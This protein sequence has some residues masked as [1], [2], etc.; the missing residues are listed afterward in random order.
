VNFLSPIHLFALA[1]VA[2]P[3]LIH[4]FSRRRVPEIPFSTIRFLRRSDRRSMVRINVRRL[5]LL[6]LRILAV[7]CIAMAFARPVVRGALASL[8]PAGGSRAACILLDRSYSMGIEGDEGAA[9]DRGLARLASILDNLERGDA[10]AIVLFDTATD[11]LYDGELEKAAALGALKG[12]RPSWGGTDLRSA[13]AF[14]K[15]KLEDGGRE[16]RELYIISDFQ[17]TALAG[18]TGDA[19]G[20]AGE[21]RAGAELPVRAFLLPVQT[22]AAAN[23]AIEEI[24]APRV[25][26]HRGEMAELTI[27]LRNT[28]EELAA[29]FP[30]EV[31]IG[32]RR[33]MEK[34]IEILPDNYFKEKVA[35]PAERSG[36]IEGIV[37]KRPDRL[38]ADDT[39]YFTT[40]VREKVHVLLIADE[41]GVYLEEALNPGGREGDIAVAKREWRSF[42]AADLK[43]ADVVILGP[44]RGPSSG[45]V[46]IVDRFVSRGG[47][48]IVLLLGELK[49]AAERLSAHPLRLE[50]AEMPQGFFTLMKPASAP[51][52][53]APFDDE[54]LAALARVR[55]GC[56]ALVSG[57]PAEQAALKFSS[58]N[59]FIW[60]ERRGEGSVVFAAIDPRPEAGELVLSPYFLPLM[61]QLVLAEWSGSASAEGVLVGQSIPWRGTTGGEIACELPGGG[62]FKPER[63]DAGILVPVVADP[64]FITILD[65]AEVKAKIAVNPDCR[66][67]SELTY[68]PAREA[69]DSLGL[70]NRLVVEEGRDLIPAIHAA[71]EGREIAVPLLLVAMALFAA[72]LVV[73][74]REKGET[75]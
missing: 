41:G 22:E 65:G 64:G 56:A 9:F 63:N 44:G 48:A 4:I 60:E 2:I 26:L 71:R 34:E 46:E 38:A 8:F 58:G 16:V 45:D 13:A 29:K 28:S 54:D 50:F 23:V 57:V 20:S 40:N 32:G 43:V 19:E 59:P 62:Q 75:A 66:K 14:G 17:K 61:Q 24:L 7:T 69:A 11:V 53:L 31:S 47:K 72:E 21:G 51:G 74:Q 49:S 68:L 70:V 33:V 25:L 36:W 67:E 15:R 52:F 10:V 37:R 12:L 30:L 27:V 73:A 18:R 5:L 42:T 55:F 6:L 39:R 3:V 35:F 1:A